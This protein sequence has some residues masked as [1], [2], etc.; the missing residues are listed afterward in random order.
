[1]IRMVLASSA[2]GT[3]ERGGAEGAG[4]DRRRERGVIQFSKKIVTI[5][6]NQL[7]LWSPV[8]QQ[9]EDHSPCHSWH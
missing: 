1:M 9:R 5:A 8:L 3:T 4:E 6:T 2:V 7:Q